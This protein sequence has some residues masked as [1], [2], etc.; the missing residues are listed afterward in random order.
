MADVCATAPPLRELAPQA[1]VACHAPDPGPLPSPRPLP[2]LDAPRGPLPGGEPVLSV[3]DLVVRYGRSGWLARMRGAIPP[4]VVDGVSLALAR[5]E[6]LGLVGESG[7]GKSTILRAVAGLWPRSGGRVDL[8]GQGTLPPRMVDRDRQSLRRV[9]VV[10]QNPDASLN[11]RHSLREILAQPLR[12]YVNASPAEVE[13]RAR[14]LLADVRLDPAYLDR[15]PGQLSGGE[16]QR[17]ALARAFAAEPEVILCDEVTSALDVSVQASVLA[18]I[19][20]LCRSRGTACLFVAHDLAVVAALC[21]R[22]AVLHQGRLV[23]VGPAA[24]LCSSPAHA[25]TQTLVRIAQGHGTWAPADA[26]VAVPA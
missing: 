25:Y 11:P 12:L 2:S 16:R 14:A 21:D 15:R 8:A 24:S 5:G 4:A 10:F 6:I 26:A 7:S 22:V 1:R 18:L 19:R 23:E 13:A 20:D 17:V 3:T 9:Q